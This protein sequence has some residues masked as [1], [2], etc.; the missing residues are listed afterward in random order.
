MRCLMKLNRFA[1]GRMWEKQSPNSVAG[2]RHASNDSL[3]MVVCGPDDSIT[4]PTRLDMNPIL[5]YLSRD[6]HHPPADIARARV[7]M[8]S[9]NIT[10]QGST[11]RSYDGVGFDTQPDNAIIQLRAK[12]FIFLF[13]LYT[14]STSA[15]TS[16]PSLL[17]STWFTTLNAL[18]ESAGLHI[19]HTNAYSLIATLA[20]DAIDAAA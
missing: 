6:E 2:A 11:S 9:P 15:P 7:A 8:V 1:C 5:E 17:S 10:A 18:I 19:V 14:P 4:R 13:D 16:L 12:T 20:K 3:F